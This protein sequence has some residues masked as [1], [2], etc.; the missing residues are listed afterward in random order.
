MEFHLPQPSLLPASGKVEGSNSS[1]Q[2]K[3]WEKKFPLQGATGNPQPCL[4]REKKI[5]FLMLIFWRASFLFP[6][7]FLVCLTEKQ[8]F[9]NS[10]Q[11]QLLSPVKSSWPLLC[12]EIQ[13][14]NK[15]VELGIAGI[16][17]L[18]LWWCRG[19]FSSL[20]LSGV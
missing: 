8:E 18:L 1:Q 11:S 4:E 15:S 9:L 3:I 17:A 10:V 2:G 14:G 19:N 20:L 16:S 5:K 13:Q 12:W 6:P 7:L